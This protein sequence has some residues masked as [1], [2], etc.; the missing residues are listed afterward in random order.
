MTEPEW[1]HRCNFFGGCAMCGGPIEVRAKYFPTFLNGAYTS[2]NVIPLCN[3]CLKK[4]YAGRV[5]ITKTVKRYKVFA[6]NTQFQRA[7]TIRMYLLRQ[8]E[9]HNLYME[10]LTPYRKRFF[11]TKTLKGAD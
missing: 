6:T 8:M 1:L 9:K 7:K 4:H 2:W 5:D 10:P 11:E 3:E